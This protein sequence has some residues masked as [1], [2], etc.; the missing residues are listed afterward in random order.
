MAAVDVTQSRTPDTVTA[1]GRDALNAFAESSLLE[2]VDQFMVDL[3]RGMPATP[4]RDAALY[5]LGTGGHRMRARLAL[6]SGANRLSARDNIAAAAACELLHN[7]SLVHD[8][9]SDGDEYRRDRPTVRAIHGDDVALCAGDLLLTSAFRAATR[10]ADAA[11][12]RSLADFMAEHAGRVIGGQSVEL[13]EK[14]STVPRRLRD[15]LRATRDK[16]APLI[17]LSLNVG[18][19]TPAPARYSPALSRG[20]A[21]AI[22]LAYQILDDMDDLREMTCAMDSAR[23]HPL[24]AWRHHQPPGRAG[25]HDRIRRRCLRHVDAAL[26]RAERL[27]AQLP[28]PLSDDVFHLIE[29]LADKARR[30]ARTTPPVQKG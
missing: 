15:Y 20:I 10:V 2:Q 23:L 19:T 21:E 13:G 3:V 30:I 26:G 22:G 16:T 12:A 11:T 18:I 27:S 8:D 24:H 29:R 25:D 9:I 17:E 14:Y 6:A 4:A 7:A 28:A 1:A 5:H